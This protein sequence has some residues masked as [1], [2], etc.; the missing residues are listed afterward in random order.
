MCC[1][2]HLC[3]VH[4]L[5]KTLNVAID[6]F[7]DRQCLRFAQLRRFVI[8]RPSHRLSSHCVID[9]TASDYGFQDIKTVSLA[10]LI[11]YFTH[12]LSHVEIPMAPQERYHVFSL[13]PTLLDTLIPRTIVGNQPAQVDATRAPSPPPSTAPAQNGAARACNICLGAVF[14][15][16]DE[17]RAHFRSDWH[18]YNVKMRVA[19]SNPVTEVQFT[20][21]V[22]GECPFLFCVS[23]IKNASKRII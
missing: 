21:L 12:Y 22:D 3:S 11:L 1:L 7:Y 13:P 16:V 17:Q 18:R 19:G 5:P 23:G 14:P 2:R 9:F 20:Q 8:L 15:D 10:R 4:R 6:A